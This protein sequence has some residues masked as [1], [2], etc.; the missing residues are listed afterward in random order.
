M[1]KAT[2]ESLFR[3]LYYSQLRQGNSAVRHASVG[4]PHLW[5]APKFGRADHSVR[6]IDAL[7]FRRSS[8]GDSL[9]AVEI[10]VSLSDL[11][12]ELK[13]PEKTAAWAQYVDSF[14][15]LVPEELRRV[16]LDEIP[17]PYGVATAG[18]WGNHFQVVRR[19]KKNPGPKPL[20]MDTWRRMAGSLA[21][22]QVE[23]IESEK[24]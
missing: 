8:T 15:F 7:V 12:S 1:A 10:K 19:A 9:W 3:S 2:E 20:P 6:R 18:R 24:F 17:S 22:I 4:E 5:G 13:K 21:K 14:Y 11:R 16:A 23:K